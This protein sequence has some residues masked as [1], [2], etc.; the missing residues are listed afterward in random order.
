MAEPL[1][2]LQVLLVCLVADAAAAFFI[3][4]QLSVITAAF[5]HPHLVI[6]FVFHGKKFVGRSVGNLEFAF[7]Q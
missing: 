6:E 7:L 2:G 1:R 4:R 3:F 5:E